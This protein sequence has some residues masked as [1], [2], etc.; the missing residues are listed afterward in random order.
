[1]SNLCRRSFIGVCSAGVTDMSHKHLLCKHQYNCGDS[2]AK[3][4]IT[5]VTQITHTDTSAAKANIT[6][7]TL[8]HSH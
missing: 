3:A 7:A 6:A 2:A 8:C 1:M 5:A 4:N